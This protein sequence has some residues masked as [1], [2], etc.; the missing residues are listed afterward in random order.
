MDTTAQKPCRSSSTVGLAVSVTVALILEA[1]CWG[2]TVDD[3]WIVT[4]VAHHGLSTGHFSFNLECPFTDAVTPLGFAHLLAA[5]G[6]RFGLKSQA[7]LWALARVLGVVS[8][9]ASFALSGWQL[10]REGK[11]GAVTGM[12]LSFLALPAAV[13]AGAGLETPL[14]GLLVIAGAVLFE[15]RTPSAGALLFGSAAAWRPELAPFLLS[16]MACREMGTQREGRRVRIRA[17][18]AFLGV[19]LLPAIVRWFLFGSFIPLAAVAK[20]AEPRTALFYA[21]VTALWS[22]LGWLI[23]LRDGAF[24]RPG[25]WGIPWCAHLVALFFAGGDWMPALRLSAPLFPL[26]VWAVGRELRPTLG[27]WLGV[28]PAAGFTL[29]LGSSQGADFRAVTARRLAL[30]SA[31][32]PLLKDARV[33]AATDIGWVG[34]ATSAHIVDLAGVTDPTIAALPGGHTS[35]MIAPGLFSDR[36]V[37]TW[38]IRALDRSFRPGDPLELIVAAYLVDA[39][40]LSRNADLGFVG[41]ATLP[42]EG[43]KGQYVIARRLSAATAAIDSG[44]AAFGSRTERF[45]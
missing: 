36:D 1:F 10:G 21:T 5:S 41:V 34:R 12:A 37:D 40:L 30:I 27:F 29:A 38:V 11:R 18:S 28:I 42:L 6:S 44:A 16:W 3:A 26:M 39:R 20:V 15:G 7:D 35:K 32:A 45:F 17:F 33:V 8:Y 25:L 24:R 43:T 4:R 2:F 14:V 22:G 13:W 23:L 9:V 31:G 19:L